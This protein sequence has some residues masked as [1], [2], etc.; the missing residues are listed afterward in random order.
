MRY[1]IDKKIFETRGG[2]GCSN[3]D[4]TLVRTTCCGNFAVEDEELLDLYYDS[5]NLNKVVKLFEKQNCPF[6][7]KNDWDFE[8]I[9][10]SLIV[11][12][13]WQWAV[14]KQ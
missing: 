3:S 13:A 11:P 10:D 12:N 7:N 14:S 8:E 6:C 2:F 4:Y 5:E 9:T 1:L